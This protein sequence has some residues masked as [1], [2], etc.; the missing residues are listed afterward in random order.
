[1]NL[2]TSSIS[3]GPTLWPDQTIAKLKYVDYTTYYL[4]PTAATAREF[5]YRMNA[6]FNP[7]NAG[8]GVSD[9][10]G[11]QEYSAL[12]SRYRVIAS[13]IY[14]E[15]ANTSTQPFDV[16]IGP[17]TATAAQPFGPNIVTPLDVKRAGA[18]P[19]HKH[20]LICGG[21][22][23]TPT[24]GQYITMK[25]LV[26]DNG[27]QTDNTWAGTTGSGTVTSS[28]SPTQQTYWYVGGASHDNT[29]ASSTLGLQ[30]TVYITYY[31]HFYGRDF[32]FQ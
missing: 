26:G 18:N 30:M 19:Y 15:F 13:S 1:M 10:P 24:L 17:Y 23:V 9:V 16:A 32:E 12:Y 31:I 2:P 4:V 8:Q 6:P 28:T 14:V 22:F 5:Y 3:R 21:Q 27:P 11:L 7:I 25:K 29:P 20:K